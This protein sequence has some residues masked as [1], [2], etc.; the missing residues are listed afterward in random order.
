VN[1]YHSLVATIT[2]TCGLWAP[3]TGDHLF[4]CGAISRPPQPP[5]NDEAWNYA[6]IASTGVRMY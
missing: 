4:T 3:T 2:A 1:F 5:G 6:H